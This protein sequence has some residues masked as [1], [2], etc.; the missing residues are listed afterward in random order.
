MG[1]SA[2]Q[3]R[4]LTITA[5]KSD[6]EYQSMQ[7]SHQKLAISRQLEDVSNEYQNSLEQTKLVYDF[8]GTG[9]ANTPLSY[10]ILMTP[11]ELNEY[12]P[13][14][15]TNSSG[16]VIL[17]SA[18][19]AA[20]EAAG[21][22]KEGLGC[23]PSDTVRNMFLQGLYDAGLITKQR[24]DKFSKT[25]YNQLAGLGAV[26][27]VAI[28]TQ[29][30]SYQELGQLLEQQGFVDPLDTVFNK[31]ITRGV[32]LYNGYDKLISSNMSNADDKLFGNN[33]TEENMT[34]KDILDGNYYLV[35]SGMDE[36]NSQLIDPGSAVDAIANSSFWDTMF[37]A[38]ESI[39]DTGDAYTQDALAYA[40]QEI[41]FLVQNQADPELY[42]GDKRAL[43]NQINNG[44]ITNFVA[45]TGGADQEK[46]RNVLAKSK[47]FA[48]QNKDGFI[49]YTLRFNCGKGS[50]DDSD[51][52]CVSMNLS[53]MMRAYLTFFTQKMQGLANSPY[54]VGTQLATSNLV[55]DSAL[56]TINSG[57][58][59]T[60]DELKMINFYD[61]LLNQLCTRGWAENEQIDDNTY[62]QEMFQSGMMFLTKVKDDGFYYQGNYATDSYIKT[63]DD[64]TKI[65]Q[66]AA[67]YETQKQRLSSKENSLDL[68]IKNLDTEISALTTEYESVK[69]TITKNIERT[70]KRYNA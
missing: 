34:L 66:A 21:I 49:G 50:D 29:E 25:A 31:E 59:I 14:L 62:L 39:L 55:G 63:V 5:R 11:S 60:E 68:K 44:V 19:A 4:L 54:Y 51:I 42:K 20:A 48:D 37:E 9:T 3:A 61:A 57:S 70:F 13:N 15:V 43:L 40:R 58:Q 8:Y 16:R 56:F 1:L 18:Y 36:K 38:F 64:E 10:G 65:A 24:V 53:S 12:M 47:D 6:C 32:G 69:G 28:N 67:K 33:A 30:V 45:V 2:G 41:E 7:F 22:P 17:N 52:S 23:T 46:D 26:S 27:S 35:A